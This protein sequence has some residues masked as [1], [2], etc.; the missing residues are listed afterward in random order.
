MAFPDGN[1][2]VRLII[3]TQGGANAASSW[4]RLNAL[5]SDPRIELRDVTLSREAV[6][7][8]I[9]ECDVFVSLHR[10]EGFGRGPAEAMLLERPV[11]ATGYSGTTDF[12]S[13]D[14]AYVVSHTLRPVRADEYPGVD[15]QH[16][17]EPD[18]Q[19]AASF[20]R[21][22]HEN[23][24]EAAELGRRGAARVKDLYNPH[25]VGLAMLAELGLGEAAPQ[26][27]PTL[28]HR[29]PIGRRPNS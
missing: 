5:C 29:R 27:V 14:C 10:S 12:I 8:M 17:A 19:E 24:R 18:T 15:G 4:R 25:R 23:P 20:M 13:A 7:K 22:C 6:L 9:A 3:K 11:I 16:W 28:S 1:E 26:E 2:P 21:R